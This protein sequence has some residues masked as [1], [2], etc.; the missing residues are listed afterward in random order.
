MEDIKHRYW[1]QKAA[2]KVR[3]IEWNFTFESWWAIWEQSGKWEKRGR[4]KGQYCMTRFNDIGSYSP[5]NVVIKLHS[6]NLTEAHEGKSIDTTHRHKL[7]QKIKNNIS[8][9][10]PHCDKIGVGPSMKRW[11]FDKCKSNKMYYKVL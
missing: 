9:T 8:Y 2:A 5:N 7:H 1:V 10:C 3:N 11:H 6:E 4:K